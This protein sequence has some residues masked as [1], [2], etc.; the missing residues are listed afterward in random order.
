MDLFERID[1]DNNGGMD[2]KELCEYIKK[3]MGEVYEKLD[4]DRQVAV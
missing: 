1:V 2:F 4:P 3:D